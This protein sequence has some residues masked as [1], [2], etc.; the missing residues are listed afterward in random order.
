ML[1][2]REPG[3]DENSLVALS[4]AARLDLGGLLEAVEI[5]LVTVAEQLGIEIPLQAIPGSRPPHL[6][7]PPAEDISRLAIR[8]QD[9]VLVDRTLAGQGAVDGVESAVQ[10]LARAIKV[11]SNV[12][13]ALWFEAAD[14]SASRLP[15]PALALRGSRLA[16]PRIFPRLFLSIERSKEGRPWYRPGIAGR[17]H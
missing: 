14:P 13:A 12:D 15:F 6:P 4:G 8:L 3:D 16:Q 5:E 9:I 10:G 1:R 17:D 7:S 2:G 11:L